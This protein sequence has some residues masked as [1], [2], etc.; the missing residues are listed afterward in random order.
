[1]DRGKLF[2]H[3]PLAGQIEIEIETN[4]GLSEMQDKLYKSTGRLIKNVALGEF[5]TEYFNKFPNN[6]E[7]E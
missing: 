6:V 1:M 2:L 4:K 5:Y 7:P 3:E